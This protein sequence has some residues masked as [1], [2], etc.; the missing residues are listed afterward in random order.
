MN[1]LPYSL[2]AT[3]IR[4][5]ILHALRDTTDVNTRAVPGNFVYQHPTV[6]SLAGFV[7]GLVGSDGATHSDLER[8]IA[9]MH[10]L[11]DKYTRNLPKHASTKSAPTS[12]VVLVTG[13]TGSLGCSLLALLVQMP[14]VSRVYA[15]NRKSQTPL[16]QRQRVSLRERGYDAEA[17]TA[18]PKLVLLEA[19]VEEEKLG[20]PDGLYQEVSSHEGGPCNETITPRRSFAHRSLTSFTMVRI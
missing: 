6:T 2:E 15:V 10:E 9:S 11:V 3:W 13:T 19:A 18:S 12:D 16:V 7:A 14:E 20:L 8:A 17:I 1:V 5:S 4:N